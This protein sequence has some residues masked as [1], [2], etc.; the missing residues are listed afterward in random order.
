[1]TRE[2]RT[3]I[4]KRICYE[5]RIPVALALV[6]VAIRYLFPETKALA[7]VSDFFVA[8]FFVGWFTGNYFRVDRQHAVQKS[9][10]SILGAA[11]RIE[12]NMA[13]AL[14]QAQQQAKADPTLEPVVKSLTALSTDVNA[15]VEDI[16]TA[17]TTVASF[18]T[19]AQ[20]MQFVGTDAL[21][22]PLSKRFYV[23]L[24]GSNPLDVSAHGPVNPGGTSDHLRAPFSSI[25]KSEH[26]GTSDDL[27]KKTAE[28][29][30]FSSI[31]KSG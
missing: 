28:S 22:K 1:M 21:G 26:A 4:A 17:S 13:G 18:L 29:E 8:L 30:A 15:Q 25:R 10:T 23:S 6:W 24:P 27:I 2:Y 20:P 7:L 19:E 12:T 5:F 31:N 14:Q 16:R 3:E 9:L 11:S